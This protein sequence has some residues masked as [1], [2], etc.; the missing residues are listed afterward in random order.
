M[1][2]SDIN[3]DGF[4]TISDVALAAYNWSDFVIKGDE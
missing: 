4:I 2:S 1:V 3:K